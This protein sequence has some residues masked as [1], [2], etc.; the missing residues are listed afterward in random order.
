MILFIIPTNVCL[1]QYFKNAY[2]MLHTTIKSLHMIEIVFQEG[3]AK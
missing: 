2:I 3:I 1:Q